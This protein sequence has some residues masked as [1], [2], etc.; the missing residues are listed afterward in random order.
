MKR[1]AEL[2]SV[3]EI[4]RKGDSLSGGKGT[5]KRSNPIPKRSL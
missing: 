5:V 1:K 3:S 4:V 2:L